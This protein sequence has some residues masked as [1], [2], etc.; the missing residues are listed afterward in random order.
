M[1]SLYDLTIKLLIRISQIFQ[2]IFKVD[3]LHHKHF[4]LLF[5]ES[6]LLGLNIS[7]LLNIQSKIIIPVGYSMIQ[8]IVPIFIFNRKINSI[9]S[10]KFNNLDKVFLGGLTG[11]GESSTSYFIDVGVL[12]N[13][14]FDHGE[15]LSP[16]GPGQRSVNTVFKERSIYIV[17]VFFEDLADSFD[18]FAFDSVPKFRFLGSH[19][20]ERLDYYSMKRSERHV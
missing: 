19:F 2:K 5:I 12:R 18:V 10:Q 7:L 6:K 17:G 15:I 20:L 9:F 3:F 8:S 16:D 4:P 13:E 11:W 1:R 14:E